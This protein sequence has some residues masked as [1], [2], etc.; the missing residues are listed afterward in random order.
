MT[1]ITN[2]DIY[3]KKKQT[4]VFVRLTSET[5]I[6]EKAKSLV[7]Q[8]L[9]GNPGKS[10]AL[11]SRSAFRIVFETSGQILRLSLRSSQFPCFLVSLCSLSPGNHASSGGRGGGAH[12]TGTRR[13]R[14][15]CDHWDRSIHNYGI[16]TAIFSS[17][18]VGKLWNVDF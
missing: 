14:T 6:N 4:N 18:P 9:G 3:N 16:K 2:K 7:H 13:P 5:Q 11:S 10:K 8:G 1:K 12:V 15:R 17:R